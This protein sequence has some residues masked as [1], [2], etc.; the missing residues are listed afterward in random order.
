[1]KKMDLFCIVLCTAFAFLALYLEQGALAPFFLIFAILPVFFE[2][3]ER[4]TLKLRQWMKKL[5][6]QAEKAPESPKP[7]KEAAPVHPEP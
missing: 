3:T 4:R 1:M 6:K 7:E 5:F 2:S